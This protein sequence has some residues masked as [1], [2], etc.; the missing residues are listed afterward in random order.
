M[1][2]VNSYQNWNEANLKEVYR[3]RKEGKSA[4]YIADELGRSETAVR[5]V[6]RKINLVKSLGIKAGTKAFNQ[7][8]AYAETRLRNYVYANT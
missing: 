2:E 1:F 3:L 4:A 6:F 7:K 8:M 5:S